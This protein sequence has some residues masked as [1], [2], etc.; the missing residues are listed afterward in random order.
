MVSRKEL[1]LEEQKSI[2]M[3][4]SSQNKETKRIRFIPDPPGVHDFPDIDVENDPVF[5]K[6]L[7]NA[8]KSLEE[9]PFPM[10]LIEESRRRDR[11][12]RNK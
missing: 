8:R 12:K 4:S 10:E 7:E 5:L 6:K 11:E 2:Y 1:I 3:T 9:C